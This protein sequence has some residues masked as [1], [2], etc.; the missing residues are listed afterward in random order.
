MTRLSSLLLRRSSLLSFACCLSLLA[1]PANAKDKNKK[2]ILPDY[3]LRATTVVVIIHPDAGE[4]I[5][6]PTANF[7]AR[8]NVERALEEWGRL[9]P[10]PEGQ[11]ADLV[12]AVKTGTGRLVQRS[13]KGGPVDNR[14]GMGQPGDI[15]IGAQQGHPPSPMG[16]PGMGPQ[17]TGPHT[18]SEIGGNEDTFE[19]YR[20][21]VP[22]PLNSSPVWRY[23]ARD[24]LRGSKLSAVEEFRKAIADAEK[25]PSSK[26]P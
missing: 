22:Q 17:N 1:A 15:R 7:T 20:G 3:V 16:D 13:I 5:D 19:V 21:G 11:D 4:P 12:I 14:T 6:E 25:Q 18:T 24:C 9:K 10:V 23:I 8:E 2:P 26:K